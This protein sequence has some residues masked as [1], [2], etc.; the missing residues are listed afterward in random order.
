MFTFWAKNRTWCQKNSFEFFLKPNISRAYQID[1]QIYKLQY[2]WC[3][4]QWYT[5][6][7][8]S[9]DF[10]LSP[11]IKLALCGACQCWRPECH[12]RH[13]LLHSC[14]ALEKVNFPPDAN[15]PNYAFISRPNESFLSNSLL[16]LSLGKNFLSLYI[17]W[18][19][20]RLS[21]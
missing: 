6:Y 3:C 17:C 16:S 2:C 20:T 14:S 21:L 15:E 19:S 18:L 12:K 7:S 5:L 9:L 10:G 11:V 13:C 1:F 8:I 4:I